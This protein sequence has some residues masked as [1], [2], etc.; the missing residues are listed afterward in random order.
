MD[1]F[2][3]VIIVEPVYKYHQLILQGLSP[4]DTSQ[5]EVLRFQP[6]YLGFVIGIFNNDNQE[7]SALV[8]SYAHLN[9]IPFILLPPFILIKKYIDV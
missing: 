7:Q 1:K 3:N 5:P 4:T 2:K 9:L 8:T 6:S